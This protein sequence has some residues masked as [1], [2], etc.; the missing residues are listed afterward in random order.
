MK[1][2]E[3]TRMTI[4]FQVT[5]DLFTLVIADDGVGFNLKEKIESGG[6]GLIN[7]QN[8]A[9]LINAKLSIATSPHTGTAVTIELPT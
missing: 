6:S 8:R 7:L 1:H 3:A 2:S 9:R 4:R 5:E